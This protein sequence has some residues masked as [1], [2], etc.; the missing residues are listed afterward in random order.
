MIS[1]RPQAQRL[2]GLLP[3]AVEAADDGL[4][5]DPARR[6]RLRVEEHLGVYDVL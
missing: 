6:V 2:L 1:W 4:E 3:G 5:R